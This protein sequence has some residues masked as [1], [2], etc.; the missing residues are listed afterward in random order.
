MNNFNIEVA[1][2][3]IVEDL[4]NLLSGLATHLFGDVPM[5][6]NEDYFPFTEPSFEL[7]IMFNNKWMEVLGMM[8][9]LLIMIIIVI[10]IKILLMK[11]VCVTVIDSSNNDVIVSQLFILFFYFYLSSFFLGCGVIHKEVMMNSDRGDRMGWAFGLGLERLAMI[12]F[13]IPDIRW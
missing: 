4:K 3:I 7:E 2:Q 12:L 5:R 8:I 13:A 6:W 10:I 1:N 11:T 9:L